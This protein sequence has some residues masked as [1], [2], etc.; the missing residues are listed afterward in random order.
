MKLKWPKYQKGTEMRKTVNS[1]EYRYFGVYLC[2]D[3][4]AESQQQTAKIIWV[5]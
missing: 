1:G 2:V 4:F 5:F 3:P